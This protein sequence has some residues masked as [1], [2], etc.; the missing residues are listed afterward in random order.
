M[1]Y[2]T[3]FDGTLKVVFETKEGRD[4]AVRLVNCL[5]KTRRMK[6]DLTKIK[7]KLDKPIEEYGIDGEFYC[8]EK[9]VD[10]IKGAEDPSIV[11]INT[12][13]STQ[14]GLWL[15]WIMRPEGD[16]VAYIEWDH[17]EK[18]YNYIPWLKYI[19]NKIIRKND[20]KI[21]DG[22]IIWSGEDA[23]DNGIIIGHNDSIIVKEVFGDPISLLVQNIKKGL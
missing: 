18:F 11:D 3:D 15:D 13:P 4:E 1:G 5:S 16:N 20:G 7:D 12:P 10:L 6:R 19:H 14:P 9:D 23:E 8:P 22:Y 21:V 2:T 17:Q